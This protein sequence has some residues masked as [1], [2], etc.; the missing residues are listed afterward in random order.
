MPHKE[1]FKNLVDNLDISDENKFES[2]I[3]RGMQSNSI[4][5]TFISD[6]MD[7]ISIKTNE[8]KLLDKNDKNKIDNIKFEIEKAIIVYEKFLYKLKE[9][10]WDFQTMGCN[11]ESM[12]IPEYIANDLWQL[13]KKFDIKFINSTRFRRLLWSPI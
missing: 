6:L 3:N 7:K 11:L 12:K 5:N 9:N 8:L 13:Q 10:N 1:Y 2:A 4:I